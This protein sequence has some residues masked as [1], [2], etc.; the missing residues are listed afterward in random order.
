MKTLIETFDAQYQLL[1]KNLTDFVKLI[2]PDKLFWK[3]VEMK[4][5]FTLYS[6]GE[7]ILRSAAAV[8]Q[9]FGGITVKLWDDP[10]EWTLPES[11]STNEKILEY[12]NEV[13]QTRQKGFEF[14]NSDE[15]LLKEIPAPEKMKTIAQLLLETAVR[16]EHF[17]GRAVAVFQMFAGRKPSA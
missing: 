14:F 6:C 9:T 4:D 15:D 5:Y 1:H 10:F 13:E 17:H 12:L 16:A 11:L 8:E 7:F 2:P 3:P